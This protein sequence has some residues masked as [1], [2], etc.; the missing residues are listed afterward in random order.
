MHYAKQC[1]THV[2][3]LYTER[4]FSISSSS[5]YTV[6]PS[7]GRCRWASETARQQRSDTHKKCISV[8]NGRRSAYIV[9]LTLTHLLVVQTSNQI[10]GGRSDYRP[11]IQFVREV[12]V[13]DGTFSGTVCTTTATN[14]YTIDS[15]CGWY[16]IVFFL[17][18]QV[19]IQLSI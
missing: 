3:F 11:Y 10:R 12:N 6:H 17:Y 16:K 7:I 5:P 4:G 2:V 15:N 14:N 1:G 8:L 19:L 18:N 13:C 9:W